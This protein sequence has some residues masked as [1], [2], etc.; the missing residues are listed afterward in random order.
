MHLLL[1]ILIALNFYIQAAG[2]HVVDD[3]LT[4]E[5]VMISS[6]LSNHPEIVELIK[7]RILGYM[8]AT[9]YV[10]LCARRL[11]LLFACSAVY[12]LTCLSLSKEL[13]SFTLFLISFPVDISEGT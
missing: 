2:L 3:V 1:Q 13:V 10:L 5:A 11:F 12:D 7:T 8:T 6:K 9:T 4:T